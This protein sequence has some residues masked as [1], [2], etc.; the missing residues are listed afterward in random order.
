MHKLSLTH[1]YTRARDTTILVLF[2]VRVRLIK[3]FAP[4]SPHFLSTIT[5]ALSPYLVHP[6][7]LIELVSPWK[8]RVQAGDFEEHAARSPLV[9][10]RSVV[11]VREETLRGSV[12]SRRDI[13]CV[14]LTIKKQS[15]TALERGVK[16][17]M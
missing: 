14:R 11:A 12:P 1:T 6:A 9:H 16:A 3:L 2:Q 8:E 13:L 15:I 7:D 5:S 17:Y 4:S 10:L